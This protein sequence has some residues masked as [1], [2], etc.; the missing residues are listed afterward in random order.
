MQVQRVIE[1]DAGQQREDVCLKTGNEYLKTGE[2]QEKSKNPKNPIITKPATILSN[3]CPASM[4]AASRME[5]LTGRARYETSSIG[6]I[7][8]IIHHGVPAGRN[9]DMK[10]VP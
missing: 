9:S 3:R 5:R 2:Y 7:S 8:H 4:F 10:C 6:I 1:I